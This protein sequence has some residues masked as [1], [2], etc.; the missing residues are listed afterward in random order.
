MPATILTTPVAKSIVVAPQAKARAAGHGIPHGLSGLACA[1]LLGLP[2]ANAEQLRQAIL[3]GLPFSAIEHLGRHLSI[4]SAEL[5]EEIQLPARTFQRRKTEDRF[6]PDESDRLVRLSQIAAKAIELFEGD[7]PGAKQWL[8][9]PAVALGGIAPLKYAQTYLGAQEVENLIER[10][11][12]G[13][14]S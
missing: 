13:I 6:H 3:E 11:E 12:D 10:L 7:A 2:Q 14:F 4:S 1:G 5:A 9:T 8:Q